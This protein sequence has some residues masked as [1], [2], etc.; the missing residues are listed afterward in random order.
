VVTNAFAKQNELQRKLLWMCKFIVIKTHNNCD[1]P[2]PVLL[3]PTNIFQHFLRNLF[4]ISDF[5]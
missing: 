1:K 4:S 2:K 5:V 3:L